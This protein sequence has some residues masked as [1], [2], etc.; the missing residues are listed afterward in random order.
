M[1]KLGLKVPPVAQGIIALILIWLLSRY[2]PVYRMNT[3]FQGAV[4]LSIIS[5][6]L[7]VGALAVGVFLKLRTTVDPRYPNKTIRLVTTGIY[8][9]SRNPMY[10]AILMVLI[11]VSVYLG[12]LSSILIL[13]IFVIYINQF[14]IVPEERS[15]EQKFG[16]S[17][18][19]YAKGVR[20]WV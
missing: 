17:Y 7:C 3:I 11:G 4:A 5:I 12:A 14:Q 13:L 19:Q 15:L 16:D 6:G 9:Y 2:W 10:L 8:K 20:R 18:R 1:F